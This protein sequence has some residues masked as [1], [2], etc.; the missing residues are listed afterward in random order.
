MSLVVVSKV[1]ASVISFDRAKRWLRIDNADEDDRIQLL[2]SAATDYV[3]RMSRMVFSKTVYQLILDNFPAV[4][5]YQY[6][7]VMAPFP[8]LLTLGKNFFLPNQTINEPVYPVTAIDW[9][10]YTDA[11]T[12]LSTTLNASEYTVDLA[13]SRVA[14]AASRVWPYA[15]NQLNSVSIQFQAGFAAGAVPSTLQMAILNYCLLSYMHPGGIPADE[16]ES[17]DRA[18]IANRE[19]VLV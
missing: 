1:A 8:Q 10:K 5:W 3:E 15:K 19:V 13:S 4:N 16:R 12:G 2:L 17:L 6:Y 7:P 11:S 14:P 9:I 18:I